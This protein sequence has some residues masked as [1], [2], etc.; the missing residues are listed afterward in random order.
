MAAGIG[1]NI[2]NAIADYGIGQNSLSLVAGPGSNSGSSSNSNPNSNTSPGPGNGSVK[3]IVK[4]YSQCKYDV[5][6]RA[7]ANLTYSIP[8]VTSGSDRFDSSGHFRKS[9]NYNS[10]Y[11]ESG[12]GADCTPNP[13]PN[14]IV[15][16]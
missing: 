2:Q 3:Y 8:G 11:C 15:K 16:Y 13:C 9:I 14:I 7:N 12:G 5:Q 10:V 6:G 4:Q 1:L